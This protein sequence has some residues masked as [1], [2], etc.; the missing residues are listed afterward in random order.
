MCCHLSPLKA[1]SGGSQACWSASPAGLG[2]LLADQVQSTA[3]HPG[4]RCPKFRFRVTHMIQPQ[5]PEVA[6]VLPRR[7]PPSARLLRRPA[8]HSLGWL[9]RTLAGARVCAHLGIM[10]PALCFLCLPPRQASQQRQENM[11]SCV[12]FV[13][14]FLSL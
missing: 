13:F 6:R 3:L 7:F 8:I 5:F 9:A 11:L 1:E 4:L 2:E 14:S 12:G 10:S